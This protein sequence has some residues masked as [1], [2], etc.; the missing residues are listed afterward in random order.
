[1]YDSQNSQLHVGNTQV[2]GIQQYKASKAVKVEQ[3]L[4]FVAV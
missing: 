2:H 1:M 4:L 3:F